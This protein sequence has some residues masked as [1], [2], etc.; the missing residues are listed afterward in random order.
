M[1]TSVGEPGRG[2]SQSHADETGDAKGGAALGKVISVTDGAL[3][4][5]PAGTSYQLH[6]ACPNFDG[7]VGRPVR[8]LVRTTARKVWTVPSGGNFITPIF[9]PPKIVQGRVRVVEPRAMVVHSGCPIWVKL[10]D[11]D[12]VYDLANGAIRVGALVNVTALPGATFELAD[13]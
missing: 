8:G 6:L 11:D 2:T 1:P 7:P 10:P 12:I 4:F 13:R 9:G 5:A 3:V